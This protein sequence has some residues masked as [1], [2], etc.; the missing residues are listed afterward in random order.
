MP[1]RFGPWHTVYM[2]WQ[3]RN[4]QGLL[5]RVFAELPELGLPA[6]ACACWAWTVPASRRIPM[7]RGRRKKGPQVLGQSHG[8]RSAKGPGM[9]AD[10]GAALMV[11]LSPGPAHDGVEGRKLL[12][13]RGP[14][15]PPAYLLMARAY[16]GAATRQ[17]ARDLGYWP[18]APPRRHRKVKWE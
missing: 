2:R 15:E 12:T 10:D 16:A 11:T 8:G 18:V 13:L 7:R 14:Q 5:A 4:E 3:R 17:L 6:A 9:A 1:E